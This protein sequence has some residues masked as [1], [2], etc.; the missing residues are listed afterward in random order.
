LTITVVDFRGH[1]PTISLFRFDTVRATVTSG[2]KVKM[3]TPIENSKGYLKDG[4][5]NV[6]G[7]NDEGLSVANKRLSYEAHLTTI[8]SNVQ[9]RTKTRRLH[10]W[11]DLPLEVEQATALEMLSEEQTPAAAACRP[12]CLNIWQHRRPS[13]LGRHRRRRTGQRNDLVG[14]PAGEHSGAVQ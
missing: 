12:Q 8:S 7:D 9:E 4:E 10:S 2:H 14:E 3:S 5:R 11:M 6:A 13:R 1:G